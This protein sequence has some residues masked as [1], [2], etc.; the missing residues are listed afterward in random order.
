VDWDLAPP[1]PVELADRDVPRLGD[2]LAG[3]RIAMLVCGGIAAMKTPLVARALRKHGAEVTAFAS[4]EALRYVAEDALA[5][6]TGRGV[7]RRLSPAAEH[8]SGHAPFDGYLLPQ[9]TYDTINKVAHGIADHALTTVL[10]AALGRLERGEAAVLVAPAMHGSMH[11]AVLTASLRRL[12]ELGVRLVKPREA[13]GKHNMPDEAV[14]VAEVCRALAS[15]ARR[16][17][18]AGRP[19]LVTGG[20]T[21]VPIDA[22]RRIT[23]RFS[24]KLGLAIAE[25]LYLEGADVWL[26]HGDGAFAAPAWL[27]HS[28]TRTYD[29]YRAAVHQRLAAGDVVAGVFA[30]AVADYQPV[31]VLP[32]KTPSGRSFSIA[33]EPTAKVIDEVRAAHPTLP[34]VTFKYLEDVS[35]DQLMAVAGERLRRFEVVVANRGEELGCGGA[36]IA[37]L[38]ARGQQPQRLDGKPAIARAIAEHL[39]TLLKD[40]PTTEPP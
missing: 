16:S 26:I 29:A 30:A 4:P 19:I 23:T 39:K 40:R 32:G 2:E 11:N 9:A 28:V 13:Y 34:M 22:V 14:L 27:P 8:L 21:P 5:W 7:I 10:A 33:L 12:R 18:L 36:H 3:R 17:P 31:E 20:P 1:P 24:G 38:L 15:I 25:R 6:A 35:H 37:W